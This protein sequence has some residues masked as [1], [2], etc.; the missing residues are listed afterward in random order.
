MTAQFHSIAELIHMNGY[1]SYVWACYGI[2]FVCVMA[3]VIYARKERKTAIAKLTQQ[4]TKLTNKQRKQ[5]ST[6]GS[7]L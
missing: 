6:T 1:G 4:S 3:L 5:L 7:L 2:V